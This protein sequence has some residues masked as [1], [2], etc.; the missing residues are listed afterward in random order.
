MLADSEVL[1]HKCVQS[2]YSLVQRKF[3]LKSS[4][5]NMSAEACDPLSGHGR[6]S[7]WETACVTCTHIPFVEL[8]CVALGLLQGI[9]G[10]MAFLCAE[11]EETETRAQSSLYYQFNNS[12]QFTKW[13][14]QHHPIL[15]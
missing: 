12:L 10:E 13:F 11:K 4:S 6:G 15:C 3:S 1:L 9:L 7:G 14:F 2:N 8:I 5:G